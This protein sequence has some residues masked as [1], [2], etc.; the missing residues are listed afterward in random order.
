MTQQKAAVLQALH[1]AGPTH[2]TAETVFELARKS[3]PGIALGTVY[4][5]L[6]KMAESGE[7][8]RIPI[9]DAPDRFDADVKDH[10]HIIC[11][12]CGKIYDVKEDNVKVEIKGIETGIELIRFDVM[13]KC[14]C[15]ECNGKKYNKN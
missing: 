5:N 4:R 6:T 14:I 8:I 11:V 9:P 2:P 3:L 13:A 1:D 12:N 7:I 10:M 15:A